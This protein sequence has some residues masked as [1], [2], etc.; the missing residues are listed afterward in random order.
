[1]PQARLLGAILPHMLVVLQ[2]WKATG[3]TPGF[4]PLLAALNMGGWSGRLLFTREDGKWED[5][6]FSPSEV[7]RQMESLPP[8]RQPLVERSNHFVELSRHDELMAKWR[9]VARNATP[10]G[11]AHVPKQARQRGSMQAPAYEQHEQEPY[12]HQRPLM[13]DGPVSRARSV[14]A[15]CWDPP[16]RGSLHGPPGAPRCTSPTGRSPIAQVPGRHRPNL[17][18]SPHNDASQ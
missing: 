12:G 4:R 3:R 7:A 14:V 9:S 8:Q 11:G 2:K 17:F 10:S 13:P 16:P 18:G 5:V 15:P 1:M 6:A